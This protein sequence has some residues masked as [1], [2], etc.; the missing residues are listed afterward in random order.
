MPR[1][2]TYARV[3]PHSCSNTINLFNRFLG[4]FEDGGDNDDDADDA[5][6]GHNDD[7]DDRVRDQV[8]SH[9]PQRLSDQLEHGQEG[10]CEAVG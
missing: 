6:D 4:A 1:K 2:V 8:I 5:V 3:S 9:N 7:G 10:E